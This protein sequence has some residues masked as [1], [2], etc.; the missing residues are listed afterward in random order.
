MQLWKGYLNTLSEITILMSHGQ[1]TIC[2]NELYELKYSFLKGTLENVTC[3]TLCNAKK[4]FQTSHFVASGLFFCFI[5]L[6][7]TYNYLCSN[8]RRFNNSYGII[9]FV[10]V[11]NLTGCYSVT[12]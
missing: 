4:K 9:R 7:G 1:N 8:S 6:V 2:E 3:V 5:Y 10:G 12:R 11:T